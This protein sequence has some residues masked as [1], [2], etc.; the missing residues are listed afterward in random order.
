MSL[1]MIYSSHSSVAY[2]LKHLECCCSWFST[3][4]VKWCPCP[5]PEMIVSWLQ[6]LPLCVKTVYPCL[7]NLKFNC[8]HLSVCRVWKSRPQ[9]SSP[10]MTLVVTT[11]MKCNGKSVGL[12][13]FCSLRKMVEF[14]VNLNA[15]SHIS[16]TV[17]TA[18]SAES[19]LVLWHS[20]PSYFPAGNT[21]HT[22]KWWGFS[23]THSTSGHCPR[24]SYH[25]KLCSSGG[26]HNSAGQ[27]LSSHL[28]HYADL[29]SLSSRSLICVAI[30]G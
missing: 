3:L 20:S 9:C 11:T 10:T 24:N 6:K 22:I 5:L 28:M 21:W 4:L 23:G 17:L 25:P 12:K 1:S 26:T 19:L 13:H 14:C 30:R 7:S 2:H 29:I 18:D 8:V 27:F 16:R 15:A